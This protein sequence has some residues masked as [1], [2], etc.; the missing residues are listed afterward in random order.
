MIG[1]SLAHYEIVDLLGRGG[2]GEVHRGRDTK[3][4]REVAI[5]VLP[6]E[7]ARD[8]ER[9]A[10]FRREAKV[11]ASLNHPRIASLHGF[12]EH[13]GVHFLVMEL[14]EGEDLAVR[15]RRGPVPVDEALEIARQIAEG[16]EEAHARG[17]V[18]RDLKPQNV[19]LGAE[20]DVKILDF[21]LA[22]QSALVDE[23]DAANS[24]TITAALTQAGTLLGT[25]AYMSPEQAAG[26]KVDARTDVWAFGVILYEMLSGNRL[27]AEESTG[28][29]LAAVIRAEPD[30][31]ALPND[32]PPHVV[33]V[34]KRCLRK[35]PR[36]RWASIADVRMLLD[37]AGDEAA[38]STTKRSPL[39]WLVP[40]AVGTILGA[41][42]VV[43][44]VRPE[45]AAVDTT[46][47]TAVVRSSV[48]LPEGTQLA[49]WSSPA[50]ELSPDGR[51]LAV[52]LEQDGRQALYVR[53]LD[54]DEARLVP[55]SDGAEGPFWS[56]DG[57]WIAFGAGNISGR[58]TEPKQLRK[59][60]LDSGRTS[61]VCS[62]DDYFG[63]TWRGDGTIF[64]VNQQPTGLWR[65]PAEGGV[66]TL[67]G[68]GSRIGLAW[69]QMLP[70]G[71]RALI[72]QWTG[73]DGRI[74]TIDL[75]SGQVTDLG[76]TGTYARW[77]TSGHLLTVDLDAD[78]TAHRFDPRT[79]RVGTGSLRVLDG[80]SIIGNEAAVLSVAPNGT[81][82]KS[83]GPVDGSRHD[84]SRLWRL[85]ADGDLRPLDLE[86]EFI[87]GFDVSP[88]GRRLAMSVHMRE[89]W[90][91]DLER[92]TRLLLPKGNTTTTLAPLW[93]PDARALVFTGTGDTGDP[94]LNL[95][96]QS[97]DGVQPPRRLESRAGEFF[98]SSWIPGT[99]RLIHHGYET[100]PPM[101][102]GMM[103][104]DVE[105]P[106]EAVHRLDV[107]GFRMTPE[108]SP[109]GRW[110][111]Y[112]SNETGR[113]EVFLR[114]YPD[115]DAKIPVGPGTRPRWSPDGDR[116]YVERDEDQGASSLWSADVVTDDEA[117]ELGA[118]RR[119][120]GPGDMPADQGDD[121]ALRGWGVDPTGDGLLLLFSVPGSGEIH[122]LDLVQ[123]WTHEL[124]RMLPAEGG[125][126]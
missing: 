122:E 108:L 99:T 53:A 20:G 78:V 41:I 39:R 58:S 79:A 76:V 66:A 118:F 112:R 119:V 88:D 46:Q 103:E 35:K 26:R 38:A 126:R 42:A 31:D 63:G 109:D 28:E 77:T 107:D 105:R 3:L 52:V 24:P 124:E 71:D 75:E 14:A 69:P 120:F 123:G 91:V 70:G 11:L 113:S 56:P 33:R 59:Y 5:K 4:G 125:A 40:F 23:T 51:T 74:V 73:P 82:V 72:T 111:A 34:L 18:H 106:D 80:V 100:G 25:A 57:R 16:L 84:L 19:K 12:E 95:F 27:F 49:G 30:W 110:L 115:L 86:P 97:A 89:L 101:R 96:L 93:T 92:G 44:L 94:S 62:V 65:V 90:V 47:D 81:L 98:A 17:V 13:E 55:D 7:L 117:I 54:D 22:F 9:M 48:R 85:A 43:G 104:I 68:E 45:R 21:G 37:E 116:L 8:I 36:E 6:P 114:S 61:T 10:R 32:V 67:V 83:H 102:S 64:F 60:S 15:M 121:R 50:V 2:M 87:S 1:R 29:T